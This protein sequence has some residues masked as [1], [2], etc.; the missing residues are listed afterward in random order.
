MK[1]YKFAVPVI[2]T[3]QKIKSNT[4]IMESGIIK[5]SHAI[6]A[7]IIIWINKRIFDDRVKISSKNPI[8][9]AIPAINIKALS[10]KMNTPIITNASQI[11]MPPPLGIGREWELRM[12]GL[13][14]KAKR[15]PI[16]EIIAAQDRLKRK[17][18]I[19]AINIE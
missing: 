3:I 9:P 7:E 4:V 8:S 6:K 2:K 11:P 12:L 17:G 19:I 18:R 1:L 16:L 5:N 14:I 13:S 10:L 15:W